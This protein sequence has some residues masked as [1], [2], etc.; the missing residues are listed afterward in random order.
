MHGI[1]F[2]SLHDYARARLGTAV[3]NEIFENRFFSMSQTHPDEDFVAL[4]TRA[5]DRLDLTGEELLFDFGVFTSEQTFANLYPAFF[6][7]AGNT[8]TFL[9]TVEDRIHELVRATVPNATPP[10][11]RV[12]ANNDGTLEIVYGSPRRLCRLLEGLV[13]GTGRH[14]GETITINEQECVS[15]GAA[16]CRFHVSS[17]PTIP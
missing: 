13:V 17:D 11:L 9:L 14:Y 16:A 12:T 3:T 1:I 5:A 6:A 15:N 7:I 2:A 10:A 4:L 8:H